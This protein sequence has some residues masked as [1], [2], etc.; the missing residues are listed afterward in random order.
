MSIPDEAI[1]EYRRLLLAP[2]MGDDDHVAR[3]ARAGRSAR[4]AKRA[5]ARGI[6]GWLYSPQE[7]EAAERHFERVIVQHEA[8][9]EIEDGDA[10][11]A[12]TAWSTCRR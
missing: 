6:V 8:P 11:T 10:S 1:A 9:E 4:D 2:G 7:A 3:E 12:T 5:L